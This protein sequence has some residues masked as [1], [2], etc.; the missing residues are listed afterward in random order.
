MNI[1]HRTSNIERRMN[2]FCLFQKRFRDTRRKRLRCASDSIVRH[3]SSVIRYFAVRCLI[4]VIQAARLIIKK[5]C[6]FGMVSY[7]INV[8]KGAEEVTIFKIGFFVNIK[9]CGS[10]EIV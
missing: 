2:V 3:S 10:A 4:R 9:I 6:H 8:F 5:P 7:E 1:E